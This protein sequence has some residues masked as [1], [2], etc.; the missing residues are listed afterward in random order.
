MRNVKINF[1][2]TAVYLQRWAAVFFLIFLLSTSDGI[3]QALR[4][5][6]AI[7]F[8]LPNAKGDS[9][10]LSQFRGSVVLLDFWASWCGPCRAANEHLVKIYR[11]YRN[12]NVV[13]LSVSLDE[14]QSEWLRAVKKDKVS[15]TQLIDKKAWD[16]PVAAAWD[17]YSIPTTFL[18]DQEGNVVARNLMGAALESGINKLLKQ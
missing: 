18:I 9:I 2:N 16:S 17:V 5:E 12:Q 15:W 7:D 8:K 13:F 1:C 3:A 11:S 6:P 10:S 4:Q 14:S